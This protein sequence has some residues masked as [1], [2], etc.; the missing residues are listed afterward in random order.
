[1]SREAPTAIVCT[2]ALPCGLIAREKK[3]GNCQA[4][5]V[6]VVTDHAVH[7][8]WVNPQVNLYLVANDSSADTLA[9]RGV[10]RSRI[11]VTGIPIDPQFKEKTAAPA[12]RKKL[13]LDPLRPTVLVMGGSHGMGPMA[14]IAAGL[15]AL[16]NPPQVAV[17][18]GDNRDLHAELSALKPR[19]GLTV[20]GATRQIALLMDAADLLVSKPGGISSS[21][22]LAKGLPMIFMKPLPGQEER[23]ARILVR[24]GA[25]VQKKNLP[26]LKEAVRDLLSRP[27]AL[28]EISENARRLSRP[29]AAEDACREILALLRLHKRGV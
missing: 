10:P 23:N 25:A 9:S 21:E 22:A 14:E 12:A 15:L 19:K 5:L 17:V 2:H 16:K 20:F 26:E 4:P 27:K 28:A 11:R 7:S 24:H 29:D 6:A 8:Y 18:A 3:R 13:G 1:L